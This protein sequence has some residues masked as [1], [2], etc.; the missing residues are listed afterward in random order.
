MLLRENLTR[1]VLPAMLRNLV[2]HLESLVLRLSIINWKSLLQGFLE[3]ME[4]PRYLPK[5]SLEW[6]L[7]IQKGYLW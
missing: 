3:K 2:F 5:S 7:R 6:I 1:M 4:K